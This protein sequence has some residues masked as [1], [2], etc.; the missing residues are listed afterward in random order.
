[1]DGAR[2]I[3]IC[4]QLSTEYVND[5]DHLY[6]PLL[7]IGWADKSQASNHRSSHAMMISSANLHMRGLYNKFGAVRRQVLCA[8]EHAC[9]AGYSAV[10]AAC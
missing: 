3:G 9:N 5:A 8:L 7:A 6:L 4:E 10:T 2:A 1:M